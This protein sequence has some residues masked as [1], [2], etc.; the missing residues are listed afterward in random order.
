MGFGQHF[1]VS[2]KPERGREE[3]SLRASLQQRGDQGAEPPNL[4][5]HG[6][7]HFPGKPG[8]LRGSGFT[9]VLLKQ[10]ETAWKNTYQ[11]SVSLAY[12]EI[13]RDGPSELLIN[14]KSFPNKVGRDR[15]HTLS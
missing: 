13:C 6:N 3:N 4:L 8:M 10:S 7:C 1:L 14:L 5:A 2:Q 9:L 15:R 12:Q 11:G